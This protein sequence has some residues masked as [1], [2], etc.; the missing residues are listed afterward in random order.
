MDLDFDPFG[1]RARVAN[2]A[3]SKQHTLGA[4]IYSGLFERIFFQ[5]EVYK[6]WSRGD[7]AWQLHCYGSPGCGKVRSIV[8]F[9]DDQF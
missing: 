1:L 3:L 7:R 4:D 8:L 2:S 5:S 9:H 6:I